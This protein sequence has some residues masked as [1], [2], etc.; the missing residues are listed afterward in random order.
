MDM[1]QEIQRKKSKQEVLDNAKKLYNTRNGI[2]NA[3]ENKIFFRQ[4]DIDDITKN[5]S[6]QTDMPKLK[7]EESKKVK[8]YKRKKYLYEK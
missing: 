5:F 8:K 3:Y 6:R 4:S 2:I 1:M 7:D